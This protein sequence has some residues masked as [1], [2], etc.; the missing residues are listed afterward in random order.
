MGQYWLPV[1][2][3]KKEVIH[4]HRLGAGLKLGEQ[5]GSHVGSAL[6]VLLGAQREVRGGG[7]L[8]L[9]T[10]WHG[11]ERT[12]GGEGPVIEEYDALA[13]R[14]IGRWA[15]DQIALVGDYAE[16][17]DLDEQHKASTIY[18]E[19]GEPGGAF[20]DV[21]EDVCAVI[22]HECCG[23]FTGDGWR[24]FKYND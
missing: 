22:E 17:S 14:T 12:G 13:S 21:T 5:L 20:T 6:I 8:D 11:P 7:D 1:T 9:G 2:L 19:C 4:P 23:K 10:N 24:D 16:D 3:T 18:G 15:G